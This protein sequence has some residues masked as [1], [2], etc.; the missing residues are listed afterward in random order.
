M[1]ERLCRK[2]G[3]NQRL[4]KPR[5]PTTTGKIERFH[6]A[7]RREILGH[8]GPFADLAAAQIAIDTWVHGYNHPRPHHLLEMA[9]SAQ[10]F[11]RTASPPLRRMPGTVRRSV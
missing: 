3:I 4:T 1:F 9:T 11:A 6:K 7:L 10:S 8:S 2:N 5:S